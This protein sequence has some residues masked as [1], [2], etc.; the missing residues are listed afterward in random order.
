METLIEQD[1]V[2]ALAGLLLE[3]KMSLEMI[4]S[5]SFF[6]KQKQ[7]LDRYE[8]TI[9]DYAKLKEDEIFHR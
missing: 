5:F 9:L 7:R 4:Q 6:Q 1:D 8:R 2:N 3:L